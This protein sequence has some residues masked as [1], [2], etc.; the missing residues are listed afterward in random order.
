MLITPKKE[1]TPIYNHLIYHL[2]SSTGT[3][4]RKCIS[5]LTTCVAVIIVNMAF[6]VYIIC[7][8]FLKMSFT[9]YLFFL[10]GP[11]ETIAIGVASPCSDS[12]NDK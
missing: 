12:R 4:G 7:V 8:I 2:F 1:M 6:M 11:F 9:T 3:D 10:S 5:H